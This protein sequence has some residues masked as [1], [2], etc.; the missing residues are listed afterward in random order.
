VAFMCSQPANFLSST[1]INVDGAAVIGLLTPRLPS[2]RRRPD[3]EMPP[4]TSRHLCRERLYVKS[5]RPRRAALIWERRPLSAVRVLSATKDGQGRVRRRPDPNIPFTAL[6]Q[7]SPQEPL[8]RSHSQREAGAFQP[9]RLL[10]VQFGLRSDKGKGSVSNA[11]QAS[12]GPATSRHHNADIIRRFASLDHSLAKSVSDFWGFLCDD[13]CPG[14]RIPVG[15]RPRLLFCP[16]RAGC[17]VVAPM[18]L[19]WWRVGSRRV[20]GSGPFD[21]VDRVSYVVKCRSPRR[22]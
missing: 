19:F 12:D 4:R 8:I 7:Y 13:A 1:A 2:R 6:R 11:T 5:P 18:G 3:R 14:T 16:E 9:V 10:A 21:R 22:W 15:A 20:V 17:V